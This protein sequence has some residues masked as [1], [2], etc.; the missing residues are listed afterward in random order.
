VGPNG[1]VI[2]TSAIDD[3]DPDPTNVVRLLDGID[4]AYD[5]A[6]LG[7]RQAADGDTISLDEL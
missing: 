5:R 4:D 3:A 1:V 6:A 2:L 7:R